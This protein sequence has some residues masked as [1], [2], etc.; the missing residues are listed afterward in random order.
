MVLSER[1]PFHSLSSSRT[2]SHTPL[3][4][5]IRR[6][7]TRR[8]PRTRHNIIQPRLDRTPTPTPSLTSSEGLRI[9][10]TL[11]RPSFDPPPYPV[12]PQTNASEAGNFLDK[13]GLEGATVLAVEEVFHEIALFVDGGD[14]ER[15]ERAGVV[16]V[17]A[18]V[19]PGLIREQR[20]GLQVWFASRAGVM[21]CLGLEMWVVG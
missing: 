12:H 20:S 6:P 19:Q 5:R 15:A 14:D 17:A 9:L 2:H 1:N 13:G 18:H 11:L 8:T 3:R 10:R 4:R 21:C 16:F 7:R